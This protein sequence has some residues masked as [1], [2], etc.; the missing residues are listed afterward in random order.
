MGCG[1]SNRNAAEIKTPGQARAD[2]GVRERI[3]RAEINAK[4]REE[5]E[6]IMYD[7]DIDREVKAGT[8]SRKG[9]AISKSTTR[10]SEEVKVGMFDVEEVGEGDQMLAIKP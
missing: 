10:A 5:D 1:A 6:R 8:G 7:E 3:P 4:P 9:K 2:V